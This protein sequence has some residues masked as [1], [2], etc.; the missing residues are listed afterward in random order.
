MKTFTFKHIAFIILFIAIPF[1]TFAQ[2]HTTITTQ[3]DSSNQNLLINPGAETGDISGWIDLDDAWNAGT[4]ITPH[5]GKYFFWPA[6]KTKAYTQ[7]Y[8]DVDVSSY[9]ADSY[10]QLSGWLAN[11]DQPPHDR[12]TLAISA[13]DI[14]GNQLLYISREHRNPFWGYYEIIVKVPANCK[15]LR[16]FLI[17][18]RFVGSD[19]D[20][21]FDD[22]HLGI[23]EKAPDVFVNIT[24]ENNKKDVEID[25][26]LQ[27]SAN[28]SG[29]TDTYYTWSSSYDAIASVSDSGLVTANSSGI[30]TIQAIGNVTKAI[31]YIILASH[32]HDYIAF[33][34]PVGGEEWQSK[35]NKEITWDLFGNVGASTLSW[36]YND[37]SDWIELSTF[38]DPSV[39][40]YIWN[41]PDSNK[42]FNNCL[43]KMSWSSY[44]ITSSR[45]TIQPFVSTQVDKDIIESIPKDYLLLQNYPNPFNPTTR[46][47]YSVPNTSFVTIIVYDVLGRAVVTLV[48][49]QK[50]QGNYN[51]EF[52]ASNLPSGVYFYQIKAGKFID[53]KKMLLLK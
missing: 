41:I 16:V 51:V 29:G 18:T 26:T 48:N 49:E 9:P 42:I 33:T 17:A 5:S 43:L 35:S 32:P 4:E 52:N 50:I 37:G 28:T 7:I 11:W 8:Q 34:N 19:N 25:K 6:K 38:T 39:G 13:L 3:V 14:N 2:I 44:E 31:G 15:T 27:L 47:N 30:I 45:F 53:V 12:A 40:K 10:F 1:S 46:I 23:L 21:Y 20:A 36:S 24:S 22:L